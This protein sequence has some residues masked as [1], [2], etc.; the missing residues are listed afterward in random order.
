MANQSY[1]KMLQFHYIIS[2]IE[3]SSVSN[4]QDHQTKKNLTNHFLTTLHLG[5]LMFSRSTDMFQLA[6]TCSKSTIDTPKQCVKSV[7]S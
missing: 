5:F 6:F 4:D 2:A 3:V 1:T 7:Q